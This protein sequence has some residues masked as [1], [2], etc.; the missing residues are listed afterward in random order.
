MMADAK[1]RDSTLSDRQLAAD[2]ASSQAGVKIQKCRS[3]PA[4]ALSLAT[5]LRIHWAR[6]SEAL[7]RNARKRRTANQINME[8][9]QFAPGAADHMHPALERA[10]TEFNALLIKS[11]KNWHILEQAGAQFNAL[12]AAQA[13][14]IKPATDS[15]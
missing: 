13:F 11:A 4:S 12:C 5:Y 3:S 14:P 8:W 2:A 6:Q 9:L 15:A 1:L 7:L 10:Y